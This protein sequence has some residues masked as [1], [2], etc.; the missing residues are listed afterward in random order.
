MATDVSV[1]GFSRGGGGGAPVATRSCAPVSWEFSEAVHGAQD[2]QIS[3]SVFAFQR[4]LSRHFAAEAPTLVT[5]SRHVRRYAAGLT[6]TWAGKVGLE[7]VGVMKREDGGGFPRE[8]PNLGPR[9]LYDA[10]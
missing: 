8:D 4:S 5:C 3:H 10:P 7:W 2:D 9:S 6:V 1:L